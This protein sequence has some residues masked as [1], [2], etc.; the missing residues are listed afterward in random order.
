MT[1]NY[2]LIDETSNVVDNVVMWDGNT[3][4]WQPPANHIWF[5]VATTPALIWGWDVAI[6]D[7]V[8]IEQ[9]GAATVGFTWNGTECVTNEPK[10]LPPQPAPDQPTTDGTQT[11]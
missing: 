4:T 10:P 11:I 3:N 5:P 7:F 6:N 2:I 1:E 8:L 9:V